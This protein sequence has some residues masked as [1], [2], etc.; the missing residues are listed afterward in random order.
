M[1]EFNPLIVYDTDEFTTTFADE[2]GI[3]LIISHDSTLII[4]SALVEECI[5]LGVNA[6][7]RDARLSPSQKYVGLLRGAKIL[8]CYVKICTNKATY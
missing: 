6:Y 1:L 7:V 4:K 2:R 8:V 3:L 5:K